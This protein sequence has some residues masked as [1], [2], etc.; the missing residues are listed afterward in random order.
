MPMKPKGRTG[1]TR[2][3]KSDQKRGPAKS[4]GV[5]GSGSIDNSYRDSAAKPG[6]HGR[7]VDSRGYSRNPKQ[8]SAGPYTSD[9]FPTNYDSVGTQSGVKGDG[10]M[11][12]TPKAR[13]GY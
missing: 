6:S 1:P 2:N 12:Q 11:R 3:L 10:G 5:F 9:P 8:N 7:P 13:R 4:G